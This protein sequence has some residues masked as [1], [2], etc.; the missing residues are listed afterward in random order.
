[1]VR[2]RRQA[3]ERDDGDED[4]D[5]SARAEQALDRSKRKGALRH[6]RKG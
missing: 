2:N 4:D 5:R 1:M 3:E 6:C